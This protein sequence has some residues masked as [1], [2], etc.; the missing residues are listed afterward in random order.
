M[1]RNQQVPE[2]P[3]PLNLVKSQDAELACKTLCKFVLETRNGSGQ[4]YPPSIIRS[5]LSGLN[6]SFKENKAPFSVMSKE[7]RQFCDLHLTLDTVT[8]EWN[9]VGVKQKHV[10]ILLNED[11]GTLWATGALGTS[12]LSS[13]QHT[14]FFYLGLHFCLRGV[15][16][17]Y[18]LVA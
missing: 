8:S 13:L 14:V 3:V 10:S 6:C 1:Q 15:Q 11:E 7:D 12:T 18:D 5:L 2:D 4:P 16:E 17:Q 9:G